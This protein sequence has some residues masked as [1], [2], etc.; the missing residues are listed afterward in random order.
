VRRHVGA[1]QRVFAI[2]DTSFNLSFVGG[3]F[4]A[5]FVLPNNGRS[6]AALVAMS[7]GYLAIAAAYRA[8]ERR[9]VV[10]EQATEQAT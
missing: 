9:S 3:A 1:G 10:A 2:Y 8:S 5:A 6:L 4:I 7:A